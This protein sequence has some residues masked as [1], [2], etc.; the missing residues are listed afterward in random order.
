MKKLNFPSF[1]FKIKK[2]NNNNLIFDE[3]RKKWLL[4]NP[5]EWVRQN[6]IHFIISKNY[7]KSLI[8]CEKSFYINNVLKRYDIVVY[9]NKGD[10]KI[11]VE[12]KSPNIKIKKEHFDQVMRYNTKLRSEII[13]VT[14][15]ITHFYFKFNNETKVYQQETDLTL[16][17]R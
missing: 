11:L 14:N 4:L 9:D 2:E 13:I 12:C 17:K 1:E 7:P 16:Y 15:G 3:I 10:V 8:N 6:F 5:E